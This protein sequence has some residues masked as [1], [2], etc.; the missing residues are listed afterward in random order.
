MSAPEPRPIRVPPIYDGTVAKTSAPAGFSGIDP[1]RRRFGYHPGIYRMEVEPTHSGQQISI[2]P[3]GILVPFRTA[4]LGVEN[5]DINV[6]IDE[7]RKQV[8]RDVTAKWFIDNCKV[9]YDSQGFRELDP[10]TL[11]DE[12]VREESGQLLFKNFL[13]S[14]HGYFNQVHPSFAEI[15]HVCPADLTICVTC[16]INLLGGDDTTFGIPEV[17][18]ARMEKCPDQG[19]VEDL[20]Q[21][22]LDANVALRDF[23]TEKWQRLL[24]EY[25]GR[26]K[27]E[28]GIG[29][30][31]DSLHHIRKHL[32][33]VAPQER[34]ALAAAGFGQQ[35][36]EAQAEGM[37]E[38][39]DAFR[40]RPAEN[41]NEMMAVMM[42]T[43][44]QQ[45]QILAQV[46]ETLATITKGNTPT[47][48]P[49]KATERAPEKPTDKPAKGPKE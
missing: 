42:E 3:G 34:T 29:F 35:V 44:R 41:N 20:R 23:Y 19:I 38:L 9:N 16:R 4:T 32:H 12:A 48:T 13:Q 45:G 33:E 46:S 2:I 37:K 14:P 26:Q 7:Y 21:V 6:P 31:N 1:R 8:P 27:G 11:L 22:L 28:P 40:E 18:Q 30:F 17:I 49:D 36:A 24:G 5:F 39:A 25:E 43:Q 47:P 10:L 15:G